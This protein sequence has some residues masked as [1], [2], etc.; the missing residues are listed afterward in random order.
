MWPVACSAAAAEEGATVRWDTSEAAL[1]AVACE[2]DGA[3]AGIAAA[4]SAFRG[5]DGGLPL[6][7]VPVDAALL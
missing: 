7:E 3:I 5:E 1:P 2:Y 4:S 6:R